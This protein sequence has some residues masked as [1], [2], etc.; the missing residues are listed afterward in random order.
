LRPPAAAGEVSLGNHDTFEA[1]VTGA[2]ERTP[3][4]VRVFAEGFS[5]GGSP[6]IADGQRGAVDT[7]AASES[8]LLDLRGEW[9]IA[10][11]TSLRING[12]RFDDER[13]NGTRLTRND[14]QGSDLSAVLTKEFTAQSATLQIS[15][16]DRSGNFAARSAP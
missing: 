15:G 7:N 1:S 9:Q 8:T 14:T 6:V 4:A 11:G 2:L 3:L 16:Y 13:E 5:T 10:A 12:R